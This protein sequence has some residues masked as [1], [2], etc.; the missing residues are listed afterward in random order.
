MSVQQFH[1]NL[2]LLKASLGDPAMLGQMIRA[3]FAEVKEHPELHAVMT[4]SDFNLIAEAAREATGFKIAEK[5]ERKGKR[6]A[7]SKLRDDFEQ[8]ARDIDLG[9]LKI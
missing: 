2:E 3:V 8:L 4:E 1:E 5:L 6:G 9:S 7:G